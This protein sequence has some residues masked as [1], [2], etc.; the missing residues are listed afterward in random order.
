MDTFSRHLLIEFWGCE[1][2]IDDPATVR[3]A[4]TEAVESI[5]AT[6]IDLKVHRYL[7]QGV[8]GLA[9]LA[10]SHFSVHTWP[11]H[12]YLAADIFTCGRLT[13]PQRAIPVLE[14]YFRPQQVESKMVLRGR[15]PEADEI[16]TASSRPTSSNLQRSEEVL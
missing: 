6:L 11:E 9:M 4:I 16:D 2:G 8:T 10:E 1:S 5:N 7:P 14:N 12:S 15:R 13:E 3:E